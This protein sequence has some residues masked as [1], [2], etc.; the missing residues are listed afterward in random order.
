MKKAL[1]LVAALAFTAVAFAAN[2]QPVE[3]TFQRYWGAYA[4]KDFAKAATDILPSDLEAAKAAILPVFLEAQNHKDKDVQ[5][6]VTVFFG[7]TV[8]KSR[9]SL[10]PVDV[11]VGLNR[12]VEKAN[13]DMFEVFKNASTTIIFVRTPAA[14]EAEV[15]FQVMLRGASDMDAETLTRKNGRWWVRLSDDPKDTA[16]NFK[17]MFAK[18][19]G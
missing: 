7:R 4:K 6:M 18:Q 3:E 1:L 13:P 12:I 14:D 15:H 8:G 11:Y 16:A 9:E 2:T 17:A 19:Q 10:T 5:E